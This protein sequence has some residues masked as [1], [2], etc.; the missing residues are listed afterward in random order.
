MAGFATLGKA[1]VGGAALFGGAKLGLGLVQGLANAGGTGGD[2]GRI[3]EEG[4]EKVISERLKQAIVIVVSLL[5]DGVK[6]IVQAFA[7]GGN[8]LKQSFELI[9]AVF[10]LGG[11]IIKQVVSHVAEAIGNLLTGLA[12]ALSGLFDTTQLRIA[13]QAAQAGGQRGIAE[14]ERARENAQDRLRQGLDFSEVAAAAET[15]GASLDDVKATV[16]LGLKDMLFA[17]QEVAEEISEAPAK[18]QPQ[19]FGQ[20]LDQFSAAFNGFVDNL[21]KFAEEFDAESKRI[22]DERTLEDSR[23]LERQGISDIREIEDFNRRKA[24]AESSG[25]DQSIADHQQYLSD[26]EASRAEN[27]EA[28]NELVASYNETNLLEAEA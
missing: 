14:A 27:L 28:I 11:N 10:S 17:T 23:R 3:R 12:D 4:A 6:L 18:I 26:L 5:L 9:G 20:A 13:G 15:A 21:K 16:V 7:A 19:V 8:L 2:L 24:E 25:Y 1:A 22:F